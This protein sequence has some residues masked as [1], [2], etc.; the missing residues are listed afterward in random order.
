MSYRLYLRRVEVATYEIA[1]GDVT[2]VAGKKA[3]VVRT[4]AKAAGLANMLV[5]ID[6]IFT[7]WIDIRTGRPVLWTVDE[8]G[9]NPGDRNRS[10]V[11]LAERAGNSVPINFHVNEQSTT[12]EPQ[13]VSMADVWDYNAYLIALRNWDAPEGSTVTLEVFRGRYMWNVKTTVGP[14]ENIATE[15]GDFPAVRY[16]SHAY[17]LLRDG[18][19]A[20]DAERNFSVWISTDAARAPVKTVAETD[21]GMITVKLIDYQPGK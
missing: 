3:V 16:D 19:R 12:P 13:K 6:D 18:K 20:P 7:S 1:V 21:Y 17:K 14:H 11:R 15:M 10:E 8:P 5:K 9:E 4:H 2:D